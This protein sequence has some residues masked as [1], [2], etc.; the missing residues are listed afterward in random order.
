MRSGFFN[1]SK[2]QP[3]RIETFLPVTTDGLKGH[4]KRTLRQQVVHTV[5]TA[6]G[7]IETANSLL[8]SKDREIDDLKKR[9]QQAERK[10]REVKDCH[11]EL[12]S[13]S[14]KF[15]QSSFY[16]S[17]GD[18]IQALVAAGYKLRFANDA[19]IVELGTVVR[20]EKSARGSK[21]TSKD[22]NGKDASESAPTVEVPF[23]AYLR[24]SGKNH[25][26]QL[27][28]FAGDSHV[29]LEGMSCNGTTVEGTNEVLATLTKFIGRKSEFATTSRGCRG[30]M[31]FLYDIIDMA[32]RASD[33]A[34]SDNDGDADTASVPNST[35]G[36]NSNN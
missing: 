3:A 27:R 13:E 30:L 35:S 22:A 1:S 9:L 6:N 32:N 34:T 25:K 7:R 33:G 8:D 21:S 4:K 16:I 11:E 26:F 23:G 36:N 20:E 12:R 19:I 29:H 18:V 17:N 24:D 31:E 14:K 5:E 2:P 15:A 10:V 28:P